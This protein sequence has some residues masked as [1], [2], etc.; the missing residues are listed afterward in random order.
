MNKIKLLMLVGLL[1]LFASVANAQVSGSINITLNAEQFAQVKLAVD[2]HNAQNGTSLT[3]VQWAEQ[4]ATKAIV[5]E[6]Q[7]AAK[8]SWRDVQR[9]GAN[10]TDQE[11][12]TLFARI[13]QI[14]EAQQTPP[15]P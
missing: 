6:A 7:A 8:V 4:V 11:R 3:V 13:Q 10:L 5:S 2:A 1:S 12:A 14:K 9:Y 15:E